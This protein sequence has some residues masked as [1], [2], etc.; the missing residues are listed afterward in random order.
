M[1]LAIT[2]A[3]LKGPRQSGWIPTQ[4]CVA[5]LL[6]DKA[7]SIRSSQGASQPKGGSVE[8]LAPPKAP[9]AVS[10]RTEEFSPR[11][12]TLPSVPG[13]LCQEYLCLHSGG[14]KHGPRLPA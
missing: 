12:E 9:L 14:S 10:L 5:M 2:Q 6:L 1:R 13:D 3:K 7:S 11:S 8:V 4:S